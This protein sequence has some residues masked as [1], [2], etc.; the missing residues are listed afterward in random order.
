M[1]GLVFVCLTG[2]IRSSRGLVGCIDS[3]EFS[4]SNPIWNPFPGQI[5][6]P[7][8]FEKVLEALF[9]C[10]GGI[11]RFLG[12]IEDTLMGQGLITAGILADNFL[13]QAHQG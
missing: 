5:I 12:R 8:K 9:E 3:L 11:T 6:P 4:S 2:I 1:L 13:R 7:R 10:N